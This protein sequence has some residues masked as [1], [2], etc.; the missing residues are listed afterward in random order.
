M[1]N[2][3]KVGLLVVIALAVL[4][5]LSVRSGTLGFG[6]SSAPMRELSTVFRDVEGVKEGSPVKMAGVDVGTVDGV[7]LQPNGN[8]VLHFKVKRSVA[9]PA[10]VSAQITTSGLIG[11]RY[12]GLV[13]GAQGLQGEGGLLAA[14][15]K[16]IPA[17]ASNDPSQIG[18]NFAKVSDDLQSMTA[19]LRQVFGDPENAQKF[20]KIIDGL[21]AFSGNLGESGDVMKNINTVA[22]NFA[23]IS[24]DLKNGKGLLGQLLQNDPKNGNMA[25]TLADLNSAVKDI[26]EVMAKINSGQGTLGKLVNDPQTAEKLDNALDT[27]SDVSERLEQ[28]RTEVAFEGTSLVGENNVGKG[29]AT[30]TLQPRPTR[31]YNVGVTADGFATASRD[32]GNTRG[33]YYG[34]DFGKEAKI[35]AQFGQVFQNALLGEDVAVRVGLKDSTGGVGVDT[36]GKLPVLGSRIKYSADVYDFNGSNTAGSNSPHVDLMAR[37]DLVGKNLYGVVGYDNV[38]NQEYGSPVV[39]V[40]LRFQDDDLKYIL[41]KAL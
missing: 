25:G 4:D 7:E 29:G 14:D 6:V 41:G 24:E 36:Y 39:G 32:F 1:S 22:E 21:A 13:P 31:F 37:A 18:G 10:D 11:E 26:K 19:T 30:L 40:G 34:K 38:L 8:A 15:V 5:W 3:T 23:K 9:L 33:A 20:Q 16:V 35:T 17:A 12:V 27:F 28:F 2:E